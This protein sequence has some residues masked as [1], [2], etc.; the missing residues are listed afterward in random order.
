MT[1]GPNSRNIWDEKIADLRRYDL[2][3]LENDPLA[4]SDIVSWPIPGLTFV[5][6]DGILRSWDVERE[7]QQQAQQTQQDPDPSK[8]PKRMYLS[9]DALVALHSQKAYLAYLVIGS[10]GGVHYYM[11]VSMAQS[12]DESGADD[13]VKIAY[14]TMKSILHSVYGGVDVF[15]KPFTSDEILALIKPLTKYTGVV[16]GIPALK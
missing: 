5:R 2:D 10:K 1:Q 8:P 3:N 12:E 11:G 6:V 15:K 14:N 16:S 7:K 13:T 9:E 4:Q